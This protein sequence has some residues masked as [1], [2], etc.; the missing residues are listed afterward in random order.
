MIHSVIVASLASLDLTLRTNALALCAAILRRQ[1]AESE[2]NLRELHR[3]MPWVGLKVELSPYYANVSRS[4][5]APPFHRGDVATVIDAPNAPSSEHVIISI[6]NMTNAYRRRALYLSS[7]VPSFKGASSG[8]IAG[9]HTIAVQILESIL[10]YLQEALNAPIIINIC[11]ILISWNY[12]AS[13]IERALILDIFPYLPRILQTTAGAN[14]ECA[15]Y[16]ITAVNVMMAQLG[17]ADL[18]PLYLDSPANNSHF[19]LSCQV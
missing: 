15:S 13:A 6:D 2:R 8:I 16:I 10:E 5:H 3:R 12:D 7:S 11:K 17:P 1:A 18:L 4:H 9:G 14:L 19:S